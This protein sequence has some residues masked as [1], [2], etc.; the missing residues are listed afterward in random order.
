[1][2]LTFFESIIDLLP[3][4][5]LLLDY[6]NKTTLC[7]S[8]RRQSEEINMQCITSYKSL[9]I[10][11]DDIQVLQ[12]NISKLWSSFLQRFARRPI[13]DYEYSKPLMKH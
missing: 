12:K 10:A 3:W 4:R 13:P 11:P 8:T 9:G 1:I 6:S 7:D 2:R 5:Y